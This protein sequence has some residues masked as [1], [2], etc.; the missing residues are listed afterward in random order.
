MKAVRGA[1]FFRCSDGAFFQRALYERKQTPLPNADTEKYNNDAEVDFDRA[2][3]ARE[4]AC[5]VVG[6]GAVAAAVVDVGAFFCVVALAEDVKRGARLRESVHRHGAG[7]CDGRVCGGTT[8]VLPRVFAEVIN[9]PPVS[10]CPTCCEIQ[11][12]KIQKVVFQFV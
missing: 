11:G 8:C 9:M 1:M 6:V 10:K 12:G 7:N 4:T 3:A 2:R 5:T